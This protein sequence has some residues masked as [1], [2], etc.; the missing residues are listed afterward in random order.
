MKCRYTHTQRE[1]ERER[2]TNVTTNNSLLILTGERVR[3]AY[4]KIQAP[5][6]GTGD[7]FTA[8]LLGWI[9]H[10]LHV[11]NIIIIS[12]VIISDNRLPVR[13]LS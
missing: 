9:G 5:F 1:R 3:L 7:L 11:N 12:I 4:P 13:K 10:G 6:T 8:V 2:E